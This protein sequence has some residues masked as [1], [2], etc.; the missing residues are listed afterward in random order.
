[1]AQTSQGGRDDLL[2]TVTNLLDQ[3][4]REPADADRERFCRDTADWVRAVRDEMAQLRIDFERGIDPELL[5]RSTADAADRIAGHASSL[6]GRVRGAIGTP[7]APRPAPAPP[8]ATPEEAPAHVERAEQIRSSVAAFRERLRAERNER[9]RR[10]AEERRRFVESIR[11]SSRE[12]GSAAPTT[13]TA[14]HEPRAED[15]HPAG[16]THPAPITDDA[17]A[18]ETTTPFAPPAPPAEATPLPSATGNAA[19]SGGWS[20]QPEPAAMLSARDEG[21]RP[22]PTGGDATHPAPEPTIAAETERA[23]SS[24]VD[25][26]PAPAPCE[27]A[28][29]TDEHPADEES[30]P[31]APPRAPSTASTIDAIPAPVGED[32]ARDAPEPGTTD[33][34]A[35][36]ID[37]VPDPAAQHLPVADATGTAVAPRPLFRRTDRA[38]ADT[39]SG[40]TSDAPEPPA[41]AEDAGTFGTEAGEPSAPQGPTDAGAGSPAPS[42]FRRTDGSLPVSPPADGVRFRMRPSA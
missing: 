18:H 25:E 3:M 31:G 33:G 17:P 8:T 27:P 39:P 11:R 6:A 20:A 41:D 10:A 42:P 12:G 29:P 26:H 22:A 7:P 24:D 9:A 13:D 19:V 28:A 38:A 1:M 14:E 34:P 2:E 23:A 21:V 15:D 37:G 35:P 4:S 32:P 36:L 16:T 5:A 40:G 30:A